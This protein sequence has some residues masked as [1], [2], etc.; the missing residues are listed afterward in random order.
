MKKS[1]RVAVRVL[2]TLLVILA[3]WGA[4]KGFLGPFVKEHSTAVMVLFG[5]ATLF[6]PAI[7]ALAVFFAVVSIAVVVFLGEEYGWVISAIGGLM[8]LKWIWSLSSPTRREKPVNPP[9][10]E[11]GLIE[12]AASGMTGAIAFGEHASTVKRMARRFGL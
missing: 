11:K 3:G 5:L 8:V 2:F 7:R 6:V 1:H 9:E 10:N 4:W 12:S